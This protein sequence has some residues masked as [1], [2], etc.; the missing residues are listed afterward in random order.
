MVFEMNSTA[1]LPYDVDSTIASNINTV[2]E[3][4]STIETTNSAAD[5]VFFTTNSTPFYETVQMAERSYQNGRNDTV[6]EN[7]N[8]TIIA[9][10][11]AKNGQNETGEVESK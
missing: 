9:E 2:I 8:E 3:K 4:S 5:D 10:N 11:G 6:T 7:W 1:T